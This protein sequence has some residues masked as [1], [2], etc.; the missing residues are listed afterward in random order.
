MS[1]RQGNN[2][3]ANTTVPSIYTAGAGITVDHN[4]ITAKAKYIYETAIASATWTINHNLNDYPSVT[5]VD[6]A[7]SIFECKVTYQDEN[8]CVV[9]MNLPIKGKAYLN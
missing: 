2:I 7:G 8:T 9:E 6:T 4:V 1:I 3:I 5:V